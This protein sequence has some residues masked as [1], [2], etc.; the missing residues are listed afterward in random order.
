MLIEHEILELKGPP[1]KAVILELKRAG[2]K[3]EP[4]FA[5]ALGLTGNPYEELLKVPP[6]SNITK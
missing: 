4:A 5:K 3:T 6:N 1:F 2:L